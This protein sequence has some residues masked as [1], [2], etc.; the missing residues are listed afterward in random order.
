V[1]DD[2]THHHQQHHRHRQ[3]NDHELAHRDGGTLMATITKLPGDRKRPWRLAYS[4]GGKRVT[5]HFATDTQAN[6]ALAKWELAKDRGEEGRDMKITYGK[7]LDLFLENDERRHG[8]LDIHGNTLYGRR[9]LIKN[10]VRP[11]LGHFKLNKLSA[12]PCQHLINGASAGNKE[13]PAPD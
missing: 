12:V 1:R 5:E 9:L 2:D 8:I 3:G 11:A 7:V 6:R 4:V 13:T 10:H